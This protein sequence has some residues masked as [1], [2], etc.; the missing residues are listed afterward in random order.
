[1]ISQGCNI[2][3][4]DF[5]GSLDATQVDVSHQ[6]N[7][8]TTTN[9]VYKD[10]QGRYNSQTGSY[11]MQ[12]AILEDEGAFEA[13][14]NA[15][16]SESNE[17]SCIESDLETDMLYIYEHYIEPQ[18]PTGLYWTDSS[19]NVVGFFGHCADFSPSNGSDP[20]W[21]SCDPPN[22]DDWGTIWSNVYQYVNTA[23][24][25]YNMKF[26]FEYGYFGYPVGGSMGEYAW[27]QLDVANNC[28]YADPPGCFTS[29]PASQFYWCDSGG[30]PCEGE[31]SGSGSYLDRFYT[32]AATYVPEGQIAVGLL[33][34]GFDDSN[35]S[36]GEDRVIAQQCG[37]VLLDTAG[38]L[39]LETNGGT[40]Y[41]A[42]H[43]MPYMQVATWNDYEEGTEV[44]SGISNCY[45]SVTVQYILAP[46]RSGE[47]PTLSWSLGTS[48]AANSGRC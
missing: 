34:K 48:S 28:Q 13:D 17:I 5:Y 27:P 43:Q 20:G 1:M 26:I 21:L 31:G 38:E 23:P 12:F 36:W 45:N 47:G 25:N 30:L 22:S 8:D 35:A 44:E 39:T 3:F 24:H 4:I 33:Y 32:D 7:L 19:V 37:Q 46:G 9:S 2:S 29:N 18:S 10:L 41:W 15:S 6:F 14:C 40:S 42:T 16:G 11:P